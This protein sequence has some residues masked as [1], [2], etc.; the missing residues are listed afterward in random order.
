MSKGEGVSSGKSIGKKAVA[1]VLAAATAITVVSGFSLRRH[2]VTAGAAT[3][4]PNIEAIKSRIKN[5]IGFNILEVTPGSEKDHEGQGGTF[6]YLIAGSEPQKLNDHLP[7]L[8]SQTDADSGTATD[9]YDRRNQ[10]AN[11]LIKGLIKAHIASE[12][13]DRAPLYAAK[14]NDNE[15]Y[16]ELR[17]WDDDVEGEKEL[18][19]SSEDTVYLKDLQFEKS[20][21]G[22]FNIAGQNSYRVAEGG[23]YIQNINGSNP[24][25]PLSDTFTAED[26]DTEKS[27]YVFYRIKIE[28]RTIDEIR[29]MP[30]GTAIFSK[31]R[32]SEENAWVYDDLAT[33]RRLFDR[34]KDYGAQTEG[35]DGLPVMGADFTDSYDTASADNWYVSKILDTEPFVEVTGDEKGYFEFTANGFIYAGKGQGTYDLTVKDEDIT[36]SQDPDAK[37]QIIYSTI[38]YTGGYTNNN[39][40]LRKVL[41][42]DDDEAESVAASIHVDYE[43]P[44]DVTAAM[45]EA[46]QNHAFADYDL[47]VMSK[48]LD[49]SGDD[50]YYGNGSDYNEPGA[51]FTAAVNAYIRK[52]MPIMAD[53]DTVKDAAAFDTDDGKIASSAYGYVN[54][55]LYIFKG[56]AARYPTM[57]S[58]GFSV[59]FPVAEYA[60]TR[61]AFYDV[62]DDIRYENELRK[63]S[64][65]SE[66]LSQQVGEAQA[67]R[68]IIN[69]AGR[70]GRNR[71]T[72]IRV[73]DI[74]PE[75]TKSLT[76]RAAGFKTNTIMKL[77]PG[78]DEEN[79]SVTTI[80]TR[81]LAGLTD[82]LT[83]SYDL[84]Y[85][86]DRNKKENFVDKNMEGLA[87]YN[88]GDTYS[89]ENTSYIKMNGYLNSDYDEKSGTWDTYRASGNDISVKKAG[90]LESFIRQGYP[91]VIADDMA[92]E[93]GHVGFDGNVGLEDPVVT[94][95]GR[96]RLNIR[97]APEV[98]IDG[99]KTTSISG[100][101][102]SD[103]FTATYQWY[104]VDGDNAT[105]IP[106]ATSDTITVDATA[107]TSYECQITS[108]KAD[109]RE[110][111]IKAGEE[112]QSD[113]V[114]IKR[115]RRYFEFT[116]DD[117]R[118]NR[119]HY[120]YKKFWVYAG[121]KASDD[122]TIMTTDRFPYTDEKESVT[123]GDPIRSM[124][125]VSSDGSRTINGNTTWISDWKDG[126]KFRAIYTIDREMRDQE[127][128]AGYKGS[129]TEI[130][131]QEVTVRR[132]AGGYTGEYYSSGRAMA[133]S[134]PSTRVTDIS[135]KTVDA[136]SRLYKTLEKYSTSTNVMSQV[137]A[138]GDGEAVVNAASVS[139]PTVNIIKS[140]KLYNAADPDSSIIGGYDGNTKILSE[141]KLDFEFQVINETETTPDDT[142]YT[143]KV[144]ADI[145]SD[146][147]FGAGEE[148]I[149]T[150]VRSGGSQIPASDIKGNINEKLAPVISISAQLPENLQGAFTWKLEVTRNAGEGEDPVAMTHSSRKGVSFVGL[151]DLTKPISIRV[152]QINRAGNRGNYNLQN[153]QE[154]NLTEF[155]TYLNSPMIKKYYDIKITTKDAN[156]AE[157]Y[158]K[159]DRKDW[160]TYFDMLILG[161]GDNYG[162][163]G[164]SG[165]VMK[166][167]TKFIGDGKSV[168]FCHDN[169]NI[170]SLN[171]DNTQ[172]QKLIKY[173]SN[174]G[175]W[176]D[177]GS[178][179]D[180]IY[181]LR[182][183][184]HMDVYGI[185]DSTNEFGGQKNWSDDE[186]KIHGGILATGRQLTEAEQKKLE[187]LGYS[188][189]YEPK[190]GEK[191]NK[192]VSQV[193]GF[194]TAAIYRYNH[195]NNGEVYASDNMNSLKTHSVQQVNKGQV[196]SYPY[197][198]NKGEFSEQGNFSYNGQSTTMGVSETHGQWY[199][200]NT[201]DND[202]VVWYTVEDG[203]VDNFYGHNDCV[204]DYYIF[205]CGNITYT[206][207]GH[208]K[209]GDDVTADEAKLFVNTMIAAF[210]TSNAAPKASFVSDATGSYDISSQSI[211]AYSD[212]DV[213]TE[214]GK[215]NLSLAI[216]NTKLYFKVTDTNMAANK[217]ISAEFATKATRDE[218]N[219]KYT[220]DD[221]DILKD[222]RFYDAQYFEKT[223]KEKEVDNLESRKTYYIKV[224]D[225]IYNSL[226]SK[227]ATAS[228][229]AILYMRPT[230]VVGDSAPLKGDW[231]HLD[232]NVSHSELFR[233]G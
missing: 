79:V 47:V 217:K 119:D 64:G 97:T 58:D 56:P 143:A 161:F 8:L 83:E 199:Q 209:N 71:K 190:S 7:V 154:N 176:A 81:T 233:I 4:L 175:T 95:A 44:Q 146:G 155:G 184:A 174:V 111:T 76:A 121:L 10:Y 33:N 127:N 134:V 13:R 164:P 12:G 147:V 220:V 195:R 153:Y 221:A 204:N 80:A 223:G 6:G 177:Q 182:A 91:V 226:T 130:S 66:L 93:K 212:P 102:I 148:I 22:A 48:G 194:A 27:G 112:P 34:N 172:G 167:V 180:F 103:I 38:R 156:D 109:G 162:Q 28:A 19:L 203:N 85:I 218:K 23:H 18:D 110:I 68:Y 74:E 20:D 144:Y 14:V 96:R 21:Q 105:E 63:K 230:L 210:R 232:I 229:H 106:G 104:R 136:N 163:A 99:V 181:L 189:A 9:G 129:D 87:Y 214:K 171:K 124:R 50:V 224:P 201:N 198:I 70:R 219:N 185:S 25:K 60:G 166:E 41:D 92:D 196:T 202:I 123:A 16:H 142:T 193:Q 128:F 179:P 186:T 77:L 149:E 29:S 132:D 188:V 17:P 98:Y 52:G 43:K 145:N 131:S 11:T 206:G 82:D 46:G 231:I 15:Y 24:L 1:I 178:I 72:K 117:A 122:N 69:Y 116:S 197:E 205:N 138:D 208:A 36:T 42:V 107:D 84:I 26:F 62:Y 3:S 57:S 137:T 168:L 86:G 133:V 159:E 75:N 115:G 55:S 2:S 49:L 67:I 170:C 32:D 228:D 192:T 51:G 120:A 30:A 114:T 141:K 94:S 227:G 65:G 215:D 207:A 35:Y 40:F 160:R 150:E 191:T 53:A 165:Y 100:R 73:L 101:S 140:P 151:N 222:I 126:D 225:D 158:M 54:N 125:W 88:I 135:I 152:L 90:E 200:L 31:D 45:N 213:K 37:Y 139:A 118:V 113:I 89:V 108:L 61:S 211:R 169:I 216:N 5:N 187:D 78:Y 183:Q 59:Q 39:W 173:R 157:K